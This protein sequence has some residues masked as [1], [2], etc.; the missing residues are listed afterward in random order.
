MSS[1]NADMTLQGARAARVNDL[2]NYLT[3]LAGVATLGAFAYLVYFHEGALLVLFE[4]KWHAFG[5]AVLPLSM[6]LFQPK[7]YQSWTEGAEQRYHRYKV[8]L[9]IARTAAS[10]G[11]TAVFGAGG[12]FVVATSSHQTPNA[13]LIGGLLLCGMFLCFGGAGIGLLARSV[14]NKA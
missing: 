7:T 8:L 10:W 9:A 4:K 3:A 12:V 2:A 11:F 6:L 1:T 14:V 13:G 5:V